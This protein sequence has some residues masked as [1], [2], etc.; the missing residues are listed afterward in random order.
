MNL[1]RSSI[2]ISVGFH[3]LEESGEEQIGR[4]YKAI[5]IIKSNESK[6]SKPTN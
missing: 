4:V 2:P 6:K 1:E 5:K 3:F